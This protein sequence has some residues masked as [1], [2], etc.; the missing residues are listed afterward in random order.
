ML[1][2]AREISE[3]CEICKSYN[4]KVSLGAVIGS[5]P[6]PDAPFQDI[7]IDFTY[8]GQDNR[9]EG[10]RY[11]L[12]MVDRFTRW[13]DAIPTAREDAKAVIKWLKR[14]LIPRFGVPRMIRSDNGSHFKNEH[15]REVE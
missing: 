10:K 2:M 9:V 13:V 3:S 4:N 7:C 5:F 6:I 1:D 11:L 12:V 8:M 15:L 14:D